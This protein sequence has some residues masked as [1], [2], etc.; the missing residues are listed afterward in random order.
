MGQGD[1]YE[2]YMADPEGVVSRV[3]VTRSGR[4]GP[5]SSP[6]FCDICMDDKQAVDGFSLGCGCVER[7]IDEHFSVRHAAA[8]ARHSV[9]VTR[10]PPAF[11]VMSFV[12]R[13]GQASCKPGLRM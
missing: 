6:F 10:R 3:G 8:T 5:A 7:I 13:A 4:E 9:R 12:V 2:K 1:P 11:A